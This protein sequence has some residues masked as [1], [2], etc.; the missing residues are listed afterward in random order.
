[1]KVL[2]ILF[3]CVLFAALLF[4]AKSLANCMGKVFLSLIRKQKKNWKFYFWCVVRMCIYSAILVGLLYPVYLLDNQEVKYKLIMWIIMLVVFLFSLFPIQYVAEKYA[5]K[6]F[7]KYEDELGIVLYSFVTG[8]FIGLSLDLAWYYALAAGGVLMLVFGGL[9]YMLRTYM[10][11]RRLKSLSTE[12]NLKQK[13]EE[14]DF[15]KKD[16]K[17]RDNLE[18]MLMHHNVLKKLEPSGRHC[19]HCVNPKECAYV[20]TRE[21]SNDVFPGCE[22]VKLIRDETAKELK[23]R[24]L[25]VPSID[26]SVDEMFEK[27][28]VDCAGVCITVS[29]EKGD[30]KG[31]KE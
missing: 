20:G 27:A 17:E 12:E 31:D 16:I 9:G 6:T 8:V 19:S 15:I 28:G 24:G 5:S 13:E 1:M 30:E 3:C 23:N 14:T 2:G 22:I 11:K 21:I 29:V 10:I 26:T 4:G 18:L 25:E 7:L